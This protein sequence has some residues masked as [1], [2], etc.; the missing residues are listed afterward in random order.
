VL[1]DHLAFRQLDT[2]WQLW[3]EKGSRP[4]PRKIVITT[5]YE[6]GDPQFSA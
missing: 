1:C 4:L 6:V 2:D 3:V 5:R